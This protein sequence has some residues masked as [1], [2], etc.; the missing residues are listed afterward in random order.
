MWPTSK[1]DP[2]LFY[3]TTK[4]DFLGGSVGKERR[5]EDGTA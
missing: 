4:F 5:G 1:G 2:Y 3:K